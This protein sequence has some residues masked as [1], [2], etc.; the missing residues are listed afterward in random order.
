MSSRASYQASTLTFDK[1]IVFGY[2]A[3]EYFRSVAM[4]LT[5]PE[6]SG[7]VSNPASC[8]FRICLLTPE[9]TPDVRIPRRFLTMASR[10]LPATLFVALF[11]ISWI[12]ASNPPARLRGVAK[13]R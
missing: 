13:S 12:S 11:F 3:H 2:Q 6:I 4:M 7:H 1:S 8:E 9:A 10:R 5:L